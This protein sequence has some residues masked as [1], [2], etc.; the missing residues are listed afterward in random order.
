M[1]GS[2]GQ[3][4]RDGPQDRTGSA[5]KRHRA[6]TGPET[7]G[8]GNANNSSEIAAATCFVDTTISRTADG[9]C[10]LRFPTAMN[11]SDLA[12]RGISLYSIYRSTVKAPVPPS[13]F[14][15]MMRNH[16]GHSGACKGGCGCLLDGVNHLKMIRIKLDCGSLLSTLT[17]LAEMG[18]LS[19]QMKADQRSAEWLGT[20]L[21]QLHK[22]TC[23]GRSGSP[24]PAAGSPAAEATPSPTTAEDAVP[25]RLLES[26]GART[27]H[28]EVERVCQLL[29]E[30]MVLCL[31]VPPALKE[32][33][34]EGLLAARGVLHRS[35]IPPEAQQR[36]ESPVSHKLYQL[37]QL[38]LK[39][40]KRAEA[41]LKEKEVEAAEALKEAGRRANMTGAEGA[42]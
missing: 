17:T 34:R 13:V 8:A 14:A 29:L 18:Q 26:A 15:G 6:A 27:D 19:S 10:A 12:D 42:Q 4:G 16:K 3:R 40:R 21:A 38:T 9:E 39:H 20:E 2:G 36:G 1:S 35:L 7:G 37:L 11:A 5:Q 41:L 23:R 22:H 31:D 30:A 32:T 28:A 25:P 33:Y 24:A